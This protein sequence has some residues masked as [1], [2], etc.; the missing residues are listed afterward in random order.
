[1]I[2]G[3]RLL[4]HAVHPGPGA[5]RG[6]RGAGTPST[7]VRPTF[8][9]ASGCRGRRA[10]CSPGGHNPARIGRDAGEATGLAAGSRSHR[11]PG[12]I[13]AGR[14]VSRMARSL[15]AGTFAAETLDPDRTGSSG[16]ATAPDSRD[17]Q[18]KDPTGWS[19][20]AP[21]SAS[22][23]LPGGTQVSAVESSGKRLPFFRSVAQIGRQAARDWPTLTPG[24]LFT[25]ISSHRTSCSILPVWCGSPTSG[26]PRPT[27][28]G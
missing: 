9:G 19:L 17:S 21:S 7:E 16:G 10:G 27:T 1:M 25:V 8:R 3:P 11:G 4:R 12:G 13:V 22:A 28:T 5:R 20:P 24:E 2:V 6:D 15:V 18:H 14:Q 23:M 26:W